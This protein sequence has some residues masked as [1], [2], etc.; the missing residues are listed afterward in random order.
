MADYALALQRPELN[1]VKREKWTEADL[2]ELPAEK[3]DVFDQKA[4][5]PRERWSVCGA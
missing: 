4:G 1:I 2:D 5:Q 3:P